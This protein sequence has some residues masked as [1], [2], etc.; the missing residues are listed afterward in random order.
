MKATKILKALKKPLSLALALAVVLSLLLC[1]ASCNDDGFK[2]YTEY[3]ISFRLPDYFRK[4]TIE[5]YEICYATPGATF[6]VQVMP[7]SEIEDEEMGYKFDFS[8]SVEDYTKFF[9]AE[10]GYTG[11]EYVYD[12]ERNVAS[13]FI[14]YSDDDVDYT[15]EYYTILKSESSLYVCVMYCAESDVDNYESLFKLWGSWLSV[16]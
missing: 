3:G 9:I 8:I 1:L 11:A 7:K 2:N 14:L 6:L 5:Y 12:A 15:Y 10:N 16:E 4:K 13:F